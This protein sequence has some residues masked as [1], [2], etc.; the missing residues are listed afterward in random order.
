MSLVDFAAFVRANH[1]DEL[2]INNLRLCRKPDLP[3]MKLIA[4]VPEEPLRE[5]TVKG[6]DTFLGDLSD[7]S[8]LKTAAESL[9]NWEE[10]KLPG[11]SRDAI[12]AT[13]LVSTYTAQKL[14][15]QAFLP[16]NT[17]DTKV[18]TAIVAEL[19][20]YYDQI[21]SQAFAVYGRMRKEATERIVKHQ[22]EQE[23]AQAYTRQIEEANEE[24]QLAHEELQA[25]HEE[26]L[27]QQEEL[28][29]QQ[30]ELE[31]VTE[32]LRASNERIEG[33][34]IRRTEELYARTQELE[35]ANRQLRESDQ[36][37][38]N[39]LS[40]ISHELR[41]P[42]NFITGFASIIADTSAGPLTDRQTD[43]V[44]RTLIGAD[45]MLVLVNNLL[46][47][48]RMQAGKFE[49]TPSLTGYGDVVD[50]VVRTMRQMADQRKIAIKTDVKVADPVVLDPT[51]L[52]QVITNL[53]DNAI[54]F[55]PD[56][57][58][59]TIKAFIKGPDLVT[60]IRDFGEGIVEADIPRLFQRFMQLDMTTTRKMGGAGLGLSIADALV[61]AHGGQIGVR[62]QTGIGSTFWFTIPLEAVMQLASAEIV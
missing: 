6:L 61:R 30:E 18:A 24:L 57:S 52:I 13:D 49:L 56:G 54:K 20:R 46:D 21:Q 43:C 7:G 60:E 8:A 33:E 58:E 39:F 50:E 4:H 37:K 36:Y 25:G 42:L 1:L 41:T 15:L 28:Q 31:H 45:R 26:L 44:A 51:R 62:S 9:R 27:A 22:A 40:V 34:V 12:E 14:S 10:D 38:D 47:M 19:E 48:G 23:A 17:S 32:A 16:A 53:V 55:C 3:L 5:M 35:E 2:A 59:V 11:I 29:A